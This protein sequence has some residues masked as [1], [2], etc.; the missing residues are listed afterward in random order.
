MDRKGNVSVCDVSTLGGIAALSESDRERQREPRGV[1]WEGR[2]T[3]RQ[4]ERVS[5]QANE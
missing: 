3:K 1:K 5:F 4:K 2:E